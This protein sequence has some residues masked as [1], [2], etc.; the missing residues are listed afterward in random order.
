MGNLK[1]VLHFLA[2]GVNPS[3]ANKLNQWTPLHWAATRGHMAIV[4]VLLRNGASK[5]AKSNKGQRPC[6]MAKTDEL[7]MLL[8]V[9]EEANAE[10]DGADVTPTRSQLADAKKADAALAAE[11]ILTAIQALR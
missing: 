11:L 1:A 8:A 10:N 7:K 2:A 4:D 3:A 9:Q 6:D 5:S